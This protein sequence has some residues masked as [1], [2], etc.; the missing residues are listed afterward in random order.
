MPALCGHTPGTG[1]TLRSRPSADRRPTARS[2]STVPPRT[3]RPTRRCATSS[4]LRASLMNTF[5]TGRQCE[6]H[7][8]RLRNLYL[9]RAAANLRASRLGRHPGKDVAHDLSQGDCSFSVDGTQ[10]DVENMGGSDEFQIPWFS[11]GV[12]SLGASH[13]ASVQDSRSESFSNGF[14]V[15]FAVIT[16][17]DNDDTCVLRMHRRAQ[18]ECSHLNQERRTQTRKWTTR[19][20]TSHTVPVLLRLLDHDSSRSRL[21]QG[22]TPRRTTS[23][24]RT[25]TRHIS[26]PFVSTG[27][28]TANCSSHQCD[29]RTGR[30][31]GAEF[32]RYVFVDRLL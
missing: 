5:A 29:K 7:V 19:L 3:T 25:L 32:L 31:G 11:R 14:D 17:G 10:L 8:Q 16:L 13:T 21:L 1:R 4:L 20:R 23:S 2:R 12:S 22:G 28:A 15:D 30:N 18:T 24:H 9:R 27:S 26:T 6:H